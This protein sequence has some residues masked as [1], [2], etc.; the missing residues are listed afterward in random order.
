MGYPS[1]LDYKCMK[2]HG[3]PLDNL[4]LNHK[5]P[6]KD[7]DIYIVYKLYS[8]DNLYLQYTQVYNPHMDFQNIQVNSYTSQHYF[9]LYIAHLLHKETECKDVDHLLLQLGLKCIK[10]IKIY[11]N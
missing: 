8:M 11:F 9:V 7:F 2:R 5:F 6:D 4:H 1:N 10:S 3:K